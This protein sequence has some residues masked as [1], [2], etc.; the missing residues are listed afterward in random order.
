[1]KKPRLF[2]KRK[3]LFLV[4]VS[5]L[6]LSLFT[7]LGAIPTVNATG[8]TLVQ[9]AKGT[10]FFDAG[11]F[12]VTLTSTPISGNVLILC[13]CGA[14]YPVGSH[15]S[16]LSS[17]GTTWTSQVT[18]SADGGITDVEIWFGVVGSNAG[19]TISVTVTGGSGGTGEC[20]AD[21]CEWSGVATSSFLDKTAVNSGGQGTTMTTGT[22]ATTTQANELWIGNVGGG[23]NPPGN[24]SSPTNGFTLLDGQYKPTSYHALCYLYKIVNSTGTASAG[25]TWTSSMN[26][27]G[28]IATFYK[29]PSLSV[30]ISPA[31]ASIDLG[32]SQSFTSTV[33]GGI[34][35]YT[36]QWYLNGVL[37]GTSSTW[38]FTPSS[39]G[40]YTVYLNV[41][42]NTGAKV[43]SNVA[44]VSVAY[45]PAI[46]I[47]PVGT[48]TL[49]IS[50]SQT[51]TSTV[52][53]GTLPYSYQW[54][55]NGSV[56]SG[57]TSSSYSF[58]SSSVGTF[59]ISAKVTDNVGITASS[60]VT[61]VIVSNV[62]GVTIS[63]ASSTL[64]LGQS[65]TFTSAV[66]GGVSPYTYQWYENGV[67]EGTTSSW[68]FTPS[69][70]GSYSIYLNVTDN[71]GTK[72]KSN[73]A[74]VTVNSALS[75][76]ITPLSVTLYISQSQTFTFS[77]SGGTSPYT[78]QWYLNGTAVSGA[79]SSSWTFTPSSAG[80]YTIY[81]KVTD[82][83]SAVV[84][85][86]TATFNAIGPKG[87]TS[88]LY[89]G[90][91]NWNTNGWY[92]ILAGNG[93]ATIE[94]SIVHSGT[95]ALNSSLTPSGR[96]FYDYNLPA[97]S[98]YYANPYYVYVY[99]Y[100]RIFPNL[101][102]NM[103]QGWNNAIV[104]YGFGDN[105]SYG[106]G[107]IGVARYNGVVHWAI[108]TN[109]NLTMPNV[110]INSTYPQLNTW[111]ETE[112]AVYQGNG[113]GWEALYVN[114]AL[115]LNVTGLHN[116]PEEIQ[117]FGVGE[118]AP[119]SVNAGSVRTEF[120]ADDVLIAGVLYKPP[121]YMMQ[122]S[123]DDLQGHDVSSLVTWQL[124]NGTQLLSYIQGQ[125]T[126]KSGIYTLKTS[127]HHFQI[128]NHILSTATYGN[129]T[130]SITLNMMP[131]TSTP[132]G[133]I[134]A[135]TTVT[136]LSII[137]E[138][139]L[140][141]TFTGTASHVLFIIDFPENAS[142]ITLDG[143]NMTKWGYSASVINFTDASFSTCK[144]VFAGTASTLG[145]PFFA[146]TV[147]LVAVGVGA[148]YWFYRRLKKVK[149]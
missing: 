134:A 26:S 71:T 63:P 140:N 103:S 61:T 133:Y 25:I 89:E 105:G 10:G 81:V 93:Q 77:M 110:L 3:F 148:V 76:S 98:P 86:S 48:I 79:T 130:T 51:F 41:T 84:T 46:S 102:I 18:E 34:S 20:I 90:F 142:Y 50:Q 59:L 145:A 91:E 88:I 138:T 67:P 101:D 95:H 5:V 146:V 40:S 64:D 15:I 35:P 87:G 114:N 119:N 137:A 70:A 78:Y 38:T 27:G 16:S 73:T 52:S 60:S 128:D 42:D 54:Y 124:W 49:H 33:S 14:D 36:Y 24:G 132:S 43:E 131:E 65:E 72:V 83:V 92:S 141:L 112:L 30:S 28:C 21:V 55:K 129:V 4:T 127:Y 47:S 66:G 136:G 126:L 123:Y 69:S 99:L 109:C 106:Y 96:A 116:Y 113:N 31:S 149:L 1:M 2:L 17:Q 8:I 23:W 118:N 13:F 74:N 53:G 57:A 82:A 144:I 85:S 7:F 12:N 19:K 100:I 45:V 56:I 32:Q 111:Y 108:C 117:T 143:I 139:S 147:A 37:Q 121:I 58:S 97:V 39:A 22:T 122:W 80:T 29:Q 107:Q 115:Q 75:I 94:S 125:Y 62:L 135:N 68:T 120:E 44:S 6:A 9:S 11:T 104:Y